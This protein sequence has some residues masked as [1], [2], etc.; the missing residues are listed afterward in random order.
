MASMERPAITTIQQNTRIG[1]IA[2]SHCSPDRPLPR[3]VF[4]AF[5][6]VMLILHLGDCG[7]P[8]GLDALEEVAPV[9]ATRGGDD[10]PSDPR[11]VPLRLLRAGGVSIG[12]LFDPARAG[13]ALDCAESE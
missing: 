13:I 5:S 4:D 6:E 12:A 8:S 7:S 1:L 2:D 10:T 11:I 3:A 9:I